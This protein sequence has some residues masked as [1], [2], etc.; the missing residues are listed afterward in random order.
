MGDELHCGA[1]NA[2]F[3]TSKELMSH[4]DSCVVAKILT[5][6]VIQTWIGGDR[7]GHPIA[8]LIVAIRDSVPLVHKYA[9]AVVGQVDT[10]KRAAIHR[11]LCLSLGVPKNVFKPFENAEIVL[12]DISLEEAETILWRALESL[13]YIV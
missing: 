9:A 4:L 6:M 13:K 5:P 8:G 1:C 11:E 12:S 10:F 3:T 7:V 2:K